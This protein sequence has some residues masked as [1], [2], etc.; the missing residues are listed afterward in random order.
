MGKI[1]FLNEKSGFDA[2]LFNN[3]EVLGD[4]DLRTLSKWLN[5]K[6]K[7]NLS[8]QILHMLW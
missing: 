5:F 2:T 8:E 3:E 4:L 6:A 7:L 1:K